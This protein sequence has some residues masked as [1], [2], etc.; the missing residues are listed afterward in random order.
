MEELDHTRRFALRRRDGRDPQ[1]RARQEAVGLLGAHLGGGAKAQLGQ[2]FGDSIGSTTAS[3]GVAFHDMQPQITHDDDIIRAP[4]I[5]PD[6]LIQMRQ[7]LLLDQQSAGEEGTPSIA[8]LDTGPIDYVLHC[9]SGL[10]KGRFLY[11]NRTAQ[12]EVIGSDKND[13][14]ITLYVENANLLPRHAKIVFNNDTFQY[15]LSD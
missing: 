6:T 12:G 14:S 11:V 15:F 9:T 10:F 1:A 3:A 5:T 2:G 8:W 13:K 7:D 4:L